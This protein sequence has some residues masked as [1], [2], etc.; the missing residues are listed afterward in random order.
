[1]SIRTQGVH[2][3]GSRDFKAKQYRAV[4][5]MLKNLP[6]GARVT[7]EDVAVQTGV[8]GRAVRE[9][10]SAADGVDILLGGD[11]NGYQLAASLEEAQRLTLRLSS[12]ASRMAARVE[13]RNAKAAD[14]RRIWQ[15]ALL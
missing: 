12:Q 5:D 9:I 13:R 8:S 14:V 2:G 3:S 6:A 7:V 10:V 1:M 15:E 11:G 4:V